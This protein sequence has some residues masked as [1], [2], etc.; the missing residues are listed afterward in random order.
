MIMTLI[1]VGLIFLVVVLISIIL[2]GYIIDKRNWNNGVCKWTGEPWVLFDT[3]SQGGRGYYS[4]GHTIW[5]SWLKE[6][7]LKRDT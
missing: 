5:I 4:K 7:P 3:D 2:A 6:K 1:L